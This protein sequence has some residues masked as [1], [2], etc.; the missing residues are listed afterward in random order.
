MIDGVTG[1]SGGHVM[2]LGANPADTGGDAGHLFHWPAHAEAFE[3]PQFRYLKIAVR[4]VALV[5]EIDRDLAVA[6]Q[7]RHWVYN[8]FSHLCL[9]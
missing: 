2:R 6:L 1:F 8:D 4:N 5:V 7:P 3:S 9:L